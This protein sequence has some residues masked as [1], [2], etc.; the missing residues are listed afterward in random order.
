MRKAT[1]FSY[2]TLSE[3]LCRKKGKGPAGNKP[4]HR[5]KN[6]GKNGGWN[7]GTCAIMGRS[8]TGRKKPTQGGNQKEIYFQ[9][10]VTE[11]EKKEGGEV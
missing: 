10:L 1:D 2:K 8:L 4:G 3:A 11:E 5:K 6:G 9:N 7:R